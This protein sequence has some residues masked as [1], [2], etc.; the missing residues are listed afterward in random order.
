MFITYLPMHATLKP[1]VL[2]LLPQYFVIQQRIAF[3]AT[4]CV[5]TQYRKAAP[6]FWGTAFQYITDYQSVVENAKIKR[7]ILC[8]R[9]RL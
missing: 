4:D 3:S 9:L 5:L 8:V 6:R 1:A 2:L 7:Y